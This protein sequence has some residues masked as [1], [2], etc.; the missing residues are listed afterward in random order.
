MST[1]DFTL[2]D[3]GSVVILTPANDAAE[4]WVIEHLPKDAPAWGPKG[5]VIEARFMAAI[6]AGIQGD[7]LV[8]EELHA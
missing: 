4:D 1:A 7:G 6:V 3:H 2:R 8:V 5:V